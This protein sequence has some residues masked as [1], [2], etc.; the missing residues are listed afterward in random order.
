MAGARTVCTPSAR[1]GAR[2]AATELGGVLGAGGPARTENTSECSPTSAE[3]AAHER[4]RLLVELQG[5]GPLSVVM[6]QFYANGRPTS[7]SMGHSARQPVLSCDALVSPI[8]HR[9]RSRERSGVFRVDRERGRESRP[10]Q[11]RCTSRPGASRPRRPRSMAKVMVVDDAYSELKLMESILKSAGHEVVALMDGEA[12]RTAVERAAGRAAARHRDAQAQRYEILRA[13]RK[14]A[15]TKAT[16]VG[17]RQQQEPGER[18]GVG[19]AAGRG[20]VPRQTLHL[21]PALDDGEA[22]CPMTPRPSTRQFLLRH[23]TESVS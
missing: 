8:R 10:W 4:A 15:R 12:W 23:G 7:R 17:P 13:L 19:Q 11:P 1:N 6:A 14:D 20:R 18:P 2:E 3:S 5:L 16:P 9:G 21:R 22:I